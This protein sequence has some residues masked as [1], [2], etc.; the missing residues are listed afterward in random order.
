MGEPFDPTPYVRAP[1]ISVSSGVSLAHALV[2]ACPKAADAKVKKA[3]KHLK[4]VADQALSDITARNK[5]L[6][7]YTEE[8]SRVLDNEADRAWGAL[9]MRLQAAAMIVEHGGEDAKRATALDAMLFH[10]TTEFLKAEYSVQSTSMGSI[11]KLIESEALEPDIHRIAGPVY[12]AAVRSVQPRYEAMV[13]ERLRRDTA[14]GQNLNETVRALQAAIVNYASKVTGTVEH[15][16]PASAESARVALLPIL[17]H[18]DTTAARGTGPGAP[19]ATTPGT[20][21][22]A[23]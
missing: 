22:P 20:P 21:P 14:S 3:C 5:K 12:L 2:A 6:G 1:V 13:K 18:R 7:T 17:N 11:L 8:D 23:S 16:D 4:A 10:G 19:P 9:R 15:D